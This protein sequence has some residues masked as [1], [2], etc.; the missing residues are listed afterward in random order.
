MHL[1]RRDPLEKPDARVIDVDDSG[2]QS[3][4]HEVKL[5]G[6]E[7]IAYRERVRSVFQGLVE[8]NTALKKIRNGQPV[9]KEEIRELAE[10]VTEVDPAINLKELEQL[11]PK[12]N[13]LEL[14]IR[15]VV[16][17]DEERVEEIF[18]EFCRT[19]PKLNSNQIRFLD[20]LKS[21]IRHFGSIQLEKLY[22]NPFTALHNEG[23]DGVFPEE[24][25]ANALV[26]V[27]KQINLAEDTD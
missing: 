19:Y 21:H 10:Q 27:L 9:T 26:D 12:V 24:G 1:A 23:L 5:K 11:F 3:E 6:M 2:E 15:Q 25:E 13:K 14:V 8:Q 16:G 17:L 18:S 4:S 7:L 22:E 20:L